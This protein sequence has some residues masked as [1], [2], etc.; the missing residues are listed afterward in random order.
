[1][2]RIQALT[3]QIREE[4]EG[5]KDYAE[6]SLDYKAHGESGLAGKFRDMANDELRHA[7]VLHDLAVSEIQTLGQVYTAP[8]EMQ[9][10]WDKSHKEFVEQT[11]W[12]KMMLQM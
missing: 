12:V 9:E 10:A 7:M 2:R 3:E 11:A 4:L 5:A 8:V 1:M 6:R